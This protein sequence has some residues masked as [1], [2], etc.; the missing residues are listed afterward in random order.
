M[1][2]V[3]VGLTEK[4]PSDLRQHAF[5]RAAGHFLIVMC[6]KPLAAVHDSQRN[7]QCHA[8]V[9]PK[10]WH[11]SCSRGL[12]N[13]VGAAQQASQVSRKIL[14]SLPKIRR[15]PRFPSASRVPHNPTVIAGKASLG[16]IYERNS[17]L[18]ES[19]RRSRKGAV[20][21]DLRAELGPP[22]ILPS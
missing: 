17:G 13:V 10:C 6:S 20:G 18:P 19:C 2:N 4:N 7:M 15:W 1:V 3:T 9:P 21:Q 11:A 16:K 22:R 5:W 12:K 14:P 8:S